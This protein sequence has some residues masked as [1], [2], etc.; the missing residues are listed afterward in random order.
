MSRKYYISERDGQIS[1]KFSALAVFSRNALYKSTFYLLTYLL[2]KR[3]LV[4]FHYNP[5]HVI[6]LVFDPDYM[7][8][9]LG[10]CHTEERRMICCDLT[11]GATKEKHVTAASFVAMDNEQCRAVIASS[12]S[13]TNSV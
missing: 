3:D 8:C 4:T 12:A 13:P 10:F 9:V 5:C 2:T 6:V 7:P 11:V 1:M